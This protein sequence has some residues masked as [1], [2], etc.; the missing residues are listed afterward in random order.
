M[1]RR[2]I[3]IDDFDALIEAYRMMPDNHLHASQWSG[4]ARATAKRA[5]ERG[6]PGFY[7]GKSIKQLFDEEAKDARRRLLAEQALA[8]DAA[9]QE[10]L[11]ARRQAILARAEEGQMVGIA[12]K[13][14]LGGTVTA[15]TLGQMAQRMAREAQQL[16]EVELAKPLAD[17]ELGVT[18]LVKLSERIAKVQKQ[19]IE[20]DHEVMRLERLYLGQPTDIIGITDA[21]DGL[22]LDEVEVTIQAAVQAFQHARQNLGLTVIDGGLAQNVVDFDEDLARAKARSPINGPTPTERRAVLGRPINPE[23]L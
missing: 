6:Y 4:V 12:R 9:E 21:D 17:R 8:R 3:T 19:V 18:A 2:Q 23:D 7:A 1:G 13:V 11:D 16:L 22:T 15:A 14:A 5:W 20:T 10:R